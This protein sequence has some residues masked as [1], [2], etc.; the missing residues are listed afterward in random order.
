M[1]KNRGFTKCSKPLTFV[2]DVS[3]NIADQKDN[4]EVALKEVKRKKVL[5]M[6]NTHRAKSNGSTN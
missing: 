5:Y 2:D 1:N 4:I 6:G 3:S